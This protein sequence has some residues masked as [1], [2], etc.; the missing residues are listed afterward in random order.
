MDIF[1]VSDS[2]CNTHDL[3]ECSCQGNGQLPAETEEEPIGSFSFNN[4]LDLD[5]ADLDTGAESPDIFDSDADENLLN[6]PNESTEIPE[7]PDVPE[8]SAETPGVCFASY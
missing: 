1:T 7:T 2:N 6:V 4:Y 5:I 8:E 3:L